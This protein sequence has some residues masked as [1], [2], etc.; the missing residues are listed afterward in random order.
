V[1]DKASFI[2]SETVERISTRAELYKI[3]LHSEKAVS[4][5]L[6]RVKV[7]HMHLS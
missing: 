7:Q 4:S 6:G 2:L 5:P 3:D 1:K